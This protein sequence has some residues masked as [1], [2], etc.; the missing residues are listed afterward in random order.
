V[1]ELDVFVPSEVP[2]SD[3]PYVP[4]TRQTWPFG[5]PRLLVDVGAVAPVR[6]AGTDG[7]ADAGASDAFGAA[8]DAAIDATMTGDDGDAVALAAGT[9]APPVA[10][11][12]VFREE[13]REEPSAEANANVEAKANDEVEAKAEANADDEAKAEMP[14][15]AEG[16]AGSTDG[17]RRTWPGVR[18]APRPGT[19]APMPG[20]LSVGTKV[21]DLAITGV[22]GQGEMGV[23]YGAID[24]ES[25]RRAAVK[26]VHWHLGEN[27][28]ALRRFVTE[29][30]AVNDIRHPNIVEI[31]SFGSL[32]D[33]R[34]YFVMELLTGTSLGRRLAGG[35]VD[36]PTALAIAD[37]VACALEAAHGRGVIHRDIKPDNIFLR[38]DVPGRIALLDFGIA[39][40]GA[41][42]EP[43][44]TRTGFG[45]GTPLYMPPEQ[46]RG[47]EIG[48]S[49]DV[50]ALG[51]VLYEMLTGQPPLW[52]DNAADVI[53]RQLADVPAPLST[54]AHGLPGSLEHLLARM[55][56]KP[57]DVRPTVAEVRATLAAVGAAL[58]AAEAP[59][60]LPP[61]PSLPPPPL[62][63]T[64]GF[65]PPPL[66]YAPTALAPRTTYAPPRPAIVVPRPE[67]TDA[68]TRR[69]APV[70]IALALALG[71]LALIALI[72]A[73]AFPR[74]GEAPKAAEAEA[75][76]AVET[77]PAEPAPA[78]AAAAAP[79]PAETPAA[80]AEATAPAAATT[81]AT[82]TSTGGRLVVTTDPPEAEVRVDGELAE[83]TA[84]GWTIERTVDGPVAVEVRASRRKT[85][86]LSIDL[87]GGR[88][89][90]VPVALERR[91]ATPG[92]GAPP[93]RQDDALIKDPFA[94]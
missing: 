85:A 10:G 23:V 87:A 91:A 4:T 49:A 46:V 47:R 22:I 63:P 62:G 21:G 75:T 73:Y 20:E 37:Q 80:P 83:R 30:H 14:A 7:E 55:L 29:S 24:P 1:D 9:L 13:A 78:E 92:G 36:V 84:D 43:S 26:V 33:G 12:E 35:G 57:A 3:S 53:A 59:P 48:P 50:Y 44:A 19:P 18:A 90:E 74:T 71:A 2:V 54:R 41:G 6:A 51:G 5:V 58:T 94:P 40:L 88:L 67:I 32:T 39:K 61:P 60:R 31:E 82:A 77:T 65:A 86:R 15:P 11:P 64:P 72:V 8:V 27:A 79:A 68:T 52:A 76:P 81:A 17:R 89:T 56:A 42:D 25:G 69:R 28:E 16:T 34:P 70:V 38:D 45:L 93:R 66:A